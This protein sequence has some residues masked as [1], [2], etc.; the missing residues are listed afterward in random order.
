MLR[1]TEAPVPV[2]NR[3]IHVPRRFVVHEWGGTETVLAELAGQQLA[4]GWRPEVHTSLALSKVRREVCR[5]IPV[6]RYS[7]CYPFL[8]LDAVQRAQLDK[9]GGNLISAGLFGSLACAAGVRLYHAHTLKRLGGEVFTAARMRRKPFVVTLHGG[10]FDVPQAERD[11]MAGAQAG[12]FEWGRIFGLLFRSRQLLEEADAVICVGYGEYEK[13]RAALSHGRIHHLGN[14]VDATR[15]AN[16]NGAEFRR[17]HGI[18]G[19]AMVLACYSRFDPQK[20]QLCLV[21]AFDRLA[22]GNP[23]LHLVLAGPC[24]VPQYLEKL[25]GRIAASPFAARI[26]RLGAIESGGGALPD[27]YHGCDIFVLPSRHEPFGIVVLEAWSAGKP[28]VAANVGGLRSL[29]R[30][31]V[32]GFL[33]P[34]AD[35]EAMAEQI[36]KLAESA[37]L[38]GALG[39]AGCA[40]ARE[41]YTWAKIADETERIYQ[42]AEVR[43]APARRPTGGTLVVNAAGEPNVSQNA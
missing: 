36:R 22:G 33:A 21:E 6:R 13:A 40:L 19:D 11:Q 39:R 37:E 8:G 24:T 4:R 16:G 29:I 27:A 28:V 38:R 18:P 2:A 9:K 20:D 15:F 35:A 7:Y 25:D 30:D 12:R 17:R 43:R 26:R 14:G 1:P 34:G 23:L 42:A 5:G 41:K 32:N 31:G 3:I 10:V